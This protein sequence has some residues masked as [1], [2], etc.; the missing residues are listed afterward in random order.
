MNELVVEQLR[1][2]I[3]ITQARYP[4]FTHVFVYDNAPSHTK[5]PPG[6]I[7][8]RKMPKS[9]NTNFLFPSKDT[10]GQDAKVRME[11]G[12][13]SDGTRQPFYFPNNHP[14]SPGW[15]KG[16]AEILRERGLAHIAERRAECPGFKCE[17]G[18]IDCC[19][20]RALFCQPDFESRDSTLEEVA[21][22]IGSQVIFLPKYH[23]ELNPI[24][25]CWGYAKQKYREM[26]PSS[27]E[28]VLKENMLKALE[29]VPLLSMRK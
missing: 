14:T 15:F 3:K 9:P 23:C 13:L 7:S 21:R 10:R 18:K 28:S 8:T 22:K 11:D 12:R 27:K 29:Q 26:P 1:D 5:H 20:R 19:C 4:D 17:E 16:M 2:A 6:S 24:E 25:Q